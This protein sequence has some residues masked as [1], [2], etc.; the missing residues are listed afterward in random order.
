MIN[1]KSRLE[2]ESYL[3]LNHASHMEWQAGLRRLYGSA[4]IHCDFFAGDGDAGAMSALD[5]D[6]GQIV[7]VHALQ[8]V[9]IAG[10]QDEPLVAVIVTAGTALVSWDGQSWTELMAPFIVYHLPGFRL[11]LNSGTDVVFLRPDSRL[12]SRL[13]VSRVASPTG[14]EALVEGFLFRAR[15][16]FNDQQ[17]KS[18][19]S[20]LLKTVA[21][22][23]L[24]GEIKGSPIVP[25]TT[26]D[27][28]LVRA[29]EKIRQ[30]PGWDF[31]L[32][33]L[34]S[35]AGVSE[36]NLYYLMK[37]QTGMTPYRY[38]Q[39]CRLLRVRQ[40]LVD[41]QC[42]VPH[43]SW[44]AADEGFSHLGRFSA[45]YREHFGELPSETVGWRRRL[46]IADEEMAA[47]NPVS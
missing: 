24:S 21:S 42:S 34:A 11:R 46:L 23:L 6:A 27:R 10:W 13:P 47:S 1:T 2:L 28:R 14:L 41:C 31:D 3:R 5:S 33:A 44:Y 7:W 15:M 32:Q 9:D 26:F 4:D 16:F 35:H 8:D 45:L 20:D 39:R 40:R 36:R 30:E 18:L 22:A 29:I 43:I 12:L 38:F 19:S 25:P 37:R 17:A